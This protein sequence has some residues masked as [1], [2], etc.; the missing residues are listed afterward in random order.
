MDTRAGGLSTGFRELI[1]LLR[2]GVGCLQIPRIV[3]LQTLG[4]V[5]EKHLAEV[6]APRCSEGLHF[7]YLLPSYRLSSTWFLWTPREVPVM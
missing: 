7:W 4:L 1:F 3:L 2:P 6:K 5:L